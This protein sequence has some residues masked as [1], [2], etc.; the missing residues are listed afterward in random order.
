[1]SW[2]IW[3]LRGI[4]VIL[5]VTVIVLARL[6]Q[7]AAEP[8][9]GLDREPRT[10]TVMSVYSSD[11]TDIVMVE[12]LD[13]TGARGYNLDGVRLGGESGPVDPPRPGSPFLGTWRFEE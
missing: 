10:A 11:E 9:P 6:P 3:L 7:T 13:A 2:Q 5:V 4:G 1:M 12:Y 8:L